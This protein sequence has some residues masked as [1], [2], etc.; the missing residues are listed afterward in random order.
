MQFNGAEILHASGFNL[1]NYSSEDM[2]S[3]TQIT[4][5]MNRRMEMARGMKRG[6][7]V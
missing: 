1:G 2:A 5:E 6:R 3:L 4:H 7:K